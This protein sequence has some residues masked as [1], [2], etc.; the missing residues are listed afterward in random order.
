MKGDPNSRG[1]GDSVLSPDRKPREVS[2]RMWS[3]HMRVSFTKRVRLRS[4]S[5]F[6]CYEYTSDMVLTTQAAGM[7][8]HRVLNKGG[9]SGS[10]RMSGSNS[11]LMRAPSEKSGNRSF[12]SLS[13][14][15]TAA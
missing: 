10:I 14:A 15:G 1:R 12:T 5:Y 2:V 3:E 8:Q 4:R 13:L 9:S 7:Q 6:G 11:A